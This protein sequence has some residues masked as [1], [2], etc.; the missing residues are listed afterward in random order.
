[1][2]LQYKCSSRAN[3]VRNGIKTNTPRFTGNRRDDVQARDRNFF[4]YELIIWYKFSITK[5]SKILNATMSVVSMNLGK[6][7]M[8]VNVVNATK[9]CSLLI[10]NSKEIVQ[11]IRVKMRVE[12]VVDM[13]VP[14]SVTII[15]IFIQ[16]NGPM[17]PFW[18]QILKSVVGIKINLRIDVPKENVFNLIA[19]VD[20]DI[21]LQK[22]TIL[23]IVLGLMMPDGL[24][25]TITNQL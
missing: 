8:P 22:L 6:I 2:V 18:H 3:Q 12:I 13:S 17:L 24:I 20:E 4:V 15:L 7:M 11:F 25:S 23:M 1:M 14:R 5:L 21:K 19:M 9:A 10:R 16:L